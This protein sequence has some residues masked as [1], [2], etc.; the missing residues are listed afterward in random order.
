MVCPER[1][2]P[3]PNNRNV[4]FP[5][6]DVTGPGMSRGLQRC[7]ML[8][9]HDAEVHGQDPEERRREG[10]QCLASTD[11]ND[12]CSPKQLLS[13]RHCVAKQLFNLLRRRGA[14]P[15]DFSPFVQAWH[16]CMGRR[17]AR[18]SPAHLQ[19]AKPE[20]PPATEAELQLWAWPW[21]KGREFWA[22]ESGAAT[23][24]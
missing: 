8:Q 2:C 14:V 20:E 12:F 13:L 22:R 7:N 3:G 5:R 24:E 23:G 21:L 10:Q 1:G 19:G 17:V 6:V 11:I 16:Q 15:V 9:W 4:G 18:R